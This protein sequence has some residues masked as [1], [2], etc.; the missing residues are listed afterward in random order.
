V[1]YWGTSQWRLVRE[2]IRR[3]TG[4][5]CRS[6]HPPGLTPLSQR[7]ILNWGMVSI[8]DRNPMMEECALIHDDPDV[9]LPALGLW[10]D[11]KGIPGN[12]IPSLR[13]LSGGTQNEMHLV[14]RS[15]GRCVMRRPPT[16]ASADR[17]KAFR[18][19]ARILQALDET[20]VPHPGVLGVCEDPE[21]SRTPVLMMEFLDGWSVSALGEW[22]APFGAEKSARAG[23][24]FALVEA[25]ATLA[26]VDWVARGLED[27]GRPDGFLDRQVARWLAFYEPIRTRTIPG[28]DEVATWLRSNVPSS[29]TPGIMHGDYQFANVM[30]AHGAP[31]R[32]TAILDWDMAT[33]GDPLLDLAWCLMDWPSPPFTGFEP[34]TRP[35]DLDGMPDRSALLD[36]YEACSGRSTRNIGYYDVLA[37][38][39]RAIV[40]EASVYRER[41]GRGDPRTAPFAQR[42]LQ[43]M[44][45]AV[46]LAE[47]AS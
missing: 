15:G 10:M 37:L 39:K 29:L 21:V 38:F 7:C 47:R 34:P 14:E 27:F 40:L 5:G 25:A 16:D 30:F 11:S 31:A 3:S 43:L 32:L 22:P 9:R 13:R 8:P 45:R 24:A 18:R 17:L 28:V 1:R 19:E 4:P 2:L 44:G 35:G 33:I 46:D 36:R 6:P 42:V 12:G 26:S 41:T 20:D 23:L